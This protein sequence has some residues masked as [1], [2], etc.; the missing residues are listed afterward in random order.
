MYSCVE[1]ALRRELLVGESEKDIQL[2]PYLPEYGRR[3]FLSPFEIVIGCPILVI[4]LLM[5]FSVQLVDQ[6]Y[7]LSCFLVTF[8]TVQELPFY[9]LQAGYT[10]YV[11]ILV[12]LHFLVGRVA[13]GLYIAMVVGKLVKYNPL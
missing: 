11:L 3:V 5:L 2:S 12:S 7:N 8:S 1:V 4:P 9:M 10:P 6:P 13:V